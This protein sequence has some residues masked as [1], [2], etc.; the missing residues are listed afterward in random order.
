M[1]LTDPNLGLNYGWAFRESGW[2]DGMDDNLKALGGLVQL[3]VLNATTT[4]PPGSPSNGDR[5]IIA[6]VATGDWTGKEGQVAVRVADAWEYYE[7]E[8]GW[9]AW[10]VAAAAMMVYT[11]SVWALLG[12]AGDAGTWQHP[13]RIGPIRLWGHADGHLMKKEDADPGNDADGFMLQEAEL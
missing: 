8:E 13:H 9:Q 6:S 4:E 2:K 1:A 5:Y 3:S 10:V 7:P 12:A 11:S